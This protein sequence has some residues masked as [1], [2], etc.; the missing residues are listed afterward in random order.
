MTR[1]D[2]NLFAG[3][4]RVIIHSAKGSTWED[5]K[6]I[7]RVDGT[8]YYPDSYEGGRHISDLGENSKSDKDDYDPISD[9]ADFTGMKDEAI[10]QL[11]EIART[12]G[13]DSPEYKDL[14]DSLA[15][16]EPDQ[17]NKITAALKRGDGQNASY[18]EKDFDNLAREVIRGNFGNGQQRKDLLGENYAEVQKRVN[19]LMKGSTGSQKVSSASSSDAAKVGESAISSAGRLTVST[20]SPTINVGQTQSVYQR[21]RQRNLTK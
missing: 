20:K 14:C 2:F 6:Y 15:E 4:G 7:K 12:K 5:H 9:I 8:Y 16:G 11:Q 13:Y 18:S 21:Q 10:K 19:E 17:Y 1:P 3:R